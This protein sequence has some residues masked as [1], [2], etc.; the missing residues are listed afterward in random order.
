MES[1]IRSV[2][3]IGLLVFFAAVTL[4]FAGSIPRGIFDFVM[5]L[6]RWVYRVITYVA[7]MRDDYP[8]FRLDQ[9]GSEPAPPVPPPT[10]PPQA[11]ATPRRPKSSSERL[12]HS[13]RAVVVYES[14]YGNTHVVADHIAA[15]LKSAYDVVVT[16][17]DGAD[18]Q[19]LAD[20]RSSR[21][22]RS[23][24]H[25]WH[26]LDHEPEV[27]GRGRRED[28]DLQLDADA[29]GPGLRDWFSGLDETPPGTGRGLRHTDRWGCGGHRKSFEGHRSPAAQ[30]WA[31]VDRRPRKLLG[32]QAEPPARR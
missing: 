22:G 1:A 12:E 32:R 17:V 15:G 23:D 13:M 3:L 31:G 16:S 26:E 19:M 29:E 9:G 6:N 5:G 11:E 8:P 18:D 20:R 30:A 25:T 4:F 27:G 14:M 7:L 2:G 10:R 24:A 21:R 28:A